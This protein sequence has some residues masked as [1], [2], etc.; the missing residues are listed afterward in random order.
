MVERDKNHP[1]VIIWSLGNE[2]GYGPNHDAAAGWVRGRDPSRP[3]HYEGAI[4]R[5]WSGGRS[6]T[7]VVCPM[8]APSRRDRG[9]GR[10]GIDDPRPLILCEYSH[11]M[12]NSNGGLADYY[13]AFERHDALQGG[14]VWEWVDHGIRPRP[15]TGPRA[16]GP[17]AAT[18]A[19]MPN[20]A[21]FC[22]DGLVWPDRTPH[23]AL[24]R[25]QVPRAAG[26]RRGASASGR[27]RIRNRHDFV[28]ARPSCRGEWE[29]TVDGEAVRRGRL[30]RAPRPAGRGLDVALDAP[31]GRPGRAVRHVPLLPP[32]ADRVGAG[33][34]RGRLAA[35]RAAAAGCGP[36]AGRAG[37][38]SAGGVL[39]AAGTRAVVDP[40]RAC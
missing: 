26:R 24:A 31:G 7:D 14:F 23:P 39:E 1:S 3:L 10:D 19:T 22:A 16:T 18:S 6:A 12:G 25:A 38:P 32:R 35:A 2:S 8:Y 30:P 17:T 9:V 36:R 13:A 4:K 33:G 15:T 37:G 34:A 21:N 40:R 11:A 5:D 28:D 27:F 20:D 29:L